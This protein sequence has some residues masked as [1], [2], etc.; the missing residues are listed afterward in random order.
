MRSDITYKV[1]GITNIAARLAFAGLLTT[2]LMLT[3]LFTASPAEAA[4]ICHSDY[5]TTSGAR[6]YYRECVDGGRRVQVSGWVEDTDADG[7]CAGVYATYSHDPHRDESDW[8][9]PEG[10]RE[11]F[12]FP[13]RLGNNA[14]VHLREQ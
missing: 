11:S 3:G 4:V 10:E 14:Y 5:I 12:G 2:S 8:A 1:H 6:A 13:W 7:Q 9:C